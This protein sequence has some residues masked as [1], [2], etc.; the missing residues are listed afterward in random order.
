MIHSNQ[1][2]TK[3]TSLV[4]GTNAKK[5]ATFKRW[6]CDFSFRA[7]L[8]VSFAKKKRLNVLTCCRVRQLK[9]FIINVAMK[10]TFNRQFIMNSSLV[11]NA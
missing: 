10:I 11:K 1:E 9:N 7:L 6:M 4:N 8:F 3:S 2:R 5:A